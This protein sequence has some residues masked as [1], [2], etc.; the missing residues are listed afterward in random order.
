MDLPALISGF[1]ATLE[2]LRGA[3]AARDDAKIS[4]AT[5]AL[6]E[7]LAQIGT[8]AMAAQV[9]VLELQ[10]ANDRLQR[11]LLDLKLQLEQRQHYAL[12]EARPGAFVYRQ[13]SQ[14]GLHG[15]GAHFLCQP[16]YDDGIKRVLRF[17]PRSEWYRARWHCPHDA[18][19]SFD[20]PTR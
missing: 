7:R 19:H 6:T 9:R 4:A 17:E 1:S 11:E 5:L 8:H 13:Q 15:A 20:D 16:C 12:H 14:D 10:L 3:L 2:L 18:R